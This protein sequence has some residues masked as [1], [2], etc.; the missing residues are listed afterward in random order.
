MTV[1]MQKKIAQVVA[2]GDSEK[3]KTFA[4]KAVKEGLDIS[5]CITGVREG[6]QRA[7]RLHA[8][9]EYLLADLFKSTDAMKIALAILEKASN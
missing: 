5:A 4:L 1:E 2:D 6:L 3:A 8:S 7:G 9:G